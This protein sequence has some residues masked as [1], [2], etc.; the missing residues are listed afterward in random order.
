MQ[1]ITMAKLAPIL[2]KMISKNISEQY[3]VTQAL[4]NHGWTAD[5]KGHPLSNSLLSA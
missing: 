2:V 5:I 3:T 1:N 4:E